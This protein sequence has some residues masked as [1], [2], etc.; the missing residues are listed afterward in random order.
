MRTPEAVAT[1]VSDWL[2]LHR[3]PRRRRRSIVAYYLGVDDALRHCAEGYRL[4]DSPLVGL[5]GVQPLARRRFGRSALADV[6]ATREPSQ[7]ATE[8]VSTILTKRQAPAL[9]VLFGAQSI[10][11]VAARLGPCK[12]K[13]C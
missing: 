7:Q 4:L 11:A 8:R 2:S 10:A 13:Q 3:T 12:C 6:Q 9:Q 5:T 1:S